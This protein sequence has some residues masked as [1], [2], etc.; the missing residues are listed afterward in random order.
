LVVLSRASTVMPRLFE[1]D[2]CLLEAEFAGVGAAAGGDQEMAAIQIARL[3]SVAYD[4]PHPR[5]PVR[6]DLHHLGALANLDIL[7][8]QCIE[9]QR[10]DS[11]SSLASGLPAS[12][13]VT[14]EPSRRKGLRHFQPDRSRSDDDE[15]R[16]PPRQLERSSRWSG[17]GTL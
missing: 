14:R 1:G 5:A 10:G 12:S 6:G 7:L 8:P 17:T 13:T 15:V 3:F 16:R 9:Q 2:A 4:H 11:G